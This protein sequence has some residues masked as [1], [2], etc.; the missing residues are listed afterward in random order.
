M[1]RDDVRRTPGCTGS[2]RFPLKRGFWAFWTNF[3]LWRW[4]KAV[5]AGLAV[6]KLQLGPNSAILG[7]SPAGVLEILAFERDNW[8]HV[9][10]WTFEDYTRAKNGSHRPDVE[11]EH[12]LHAFLVRMNE[13]GRQ[14]DALFLRVLD[15]LLREEFL[16][17]ANGY[18]LTG[19][20]ED[21]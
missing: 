16:R 13:S 1:R 7:F 2:F 8:M 19:R 5:F 10:N 4:K 3:R 11:P 9:C 17:A 14:M 18:F 12:P 15:Y 6:K 20:K 21:Y